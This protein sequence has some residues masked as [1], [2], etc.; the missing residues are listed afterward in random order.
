MTTDADAASGVTPEEAFSILGN[1]T[2]L[3]ILLALREAEGVLSFSELYDR[4][5]Y[6]DYSN[7]DYHLEKLEGHFV[8]KTEAGY[9][10]LGTGRRLVAAVLSGTV[11]EEPV[12]EPARIDEACPFCGAAVEVAYQQEHV[13]LYCSA[14]PGVAR[15]VDS[16]GRYFADQ[17]FVTHFRLPPAG[18]AGRDRDE[19][20]AAAWTWG[21][22]G[23]LADSLGVCSRCAAPLEQSV[24]VCEDHEPDG[25]Y[26]DRCERR[27]AA[28]FEVDCP[29]CHYRVGGIAS[30]A[31]L[32]R[33]E[34]LAFLTA[35]G[36]NPL[37][38][39]SLDAALGTL[40]NYEEE[41]RSVDPFEGAFT[42][43]IDGDALTLTVDDDL[44]V[45]DATTHDPTAAST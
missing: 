29:N 34:M 4:V 15:D 33:T 25:G 27:Y 31:L 11:S 13:E 35:H 41:I 6:R 20:L 23:L 38:P 45:V 5:E 17:G 12:L 32:A 19:V 8:R 37:A 1:E 42:Y 7:F 24:T 40:G 43:T 9:D 16:D 26:C 14:C 44:T 30:P 39:E 10:L 22:V 28:R 21:R 3:Q 2:R 18:L 36:V